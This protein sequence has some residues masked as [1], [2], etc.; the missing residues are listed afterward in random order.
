M[1]YA[2]RGTGRLTGR[3]MTWWHWTDGW[4]LE[5]MAVAAGR[6]GHHDAMNAHREGSKTAAPAA[7]HRRRAVGARCC[8]WP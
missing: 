5:S 4:L 8:C 2:L 1:W 6:S 3:L 7:S